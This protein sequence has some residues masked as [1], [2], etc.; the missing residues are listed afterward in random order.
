MMSECYK[1]GSCKYLMTEN[2]YMSNGYGMLSFA[3]ISFTTAYHPLNPQI[4]GEF[5]RTKKFAY[6][7]LGIIILI[8]FRFPGLSLWKQ[9][10]L[11]KAS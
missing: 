1:N 8:L 9:A 4:S 11:G 3:V 5:V 7:P 6:K 2:M 10:G